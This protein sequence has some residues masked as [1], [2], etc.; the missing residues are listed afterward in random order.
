MR[1]DRPIGVGCSSGLRLERGAG[2]H[3]TK[4]AALIGW[5]A[6]GAFAMRSAGCVYNDI[7]D[8]DLDAQGGADAAAAA[9]EQSG[10]A[11]GGVGCCWSRSASSGLS[12]CCS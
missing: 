9:G 12:C 3:G 6:L 5:F 8:R 2:G 7:V 11:A 1:L 10:V 4:R